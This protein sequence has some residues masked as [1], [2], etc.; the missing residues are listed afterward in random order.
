[1][2]ISE[3]I[4]IGKLTHQRSYPKAHHFQ[5]KHVMLALD[6]DSN[7]T[8]SFIFGLNKFRI[9]SIYA[10][11]HLGG[12][13]TNFRTALNKLLKYNAKYNKN[14]QMIVLTTPSVL[15]HVFNPATFF[16][17]LYK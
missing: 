14:N 12:E 10:K 4:Y 11:N 6:V 13:N 8:S 5:Y 1:M 2:S 3:G 15:G 16:F 17:Q 7:K 9:L